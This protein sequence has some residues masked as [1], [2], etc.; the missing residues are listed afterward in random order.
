MVAFI[1]EEIIDKCETCSGLYIFEFVSC[2][3]SLISI[4]MLVVYISPL[5][6]KINIPSFKKVD[7][8][9]TLVTG[10]A[11]LLASI[12]FIATIDKSSLADTSVAFG[13]LASI[14][15]LVEVYFMWRSDY[16]QRK[17]KPKQALAANGGAEGQPLTVPVQENV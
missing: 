13:F 14:A 17:E 6:N 8:W 9:I 4:L 12:V 10:G 11:F 15:F 2:S 3:A 7:F 16:L 5:K 1:C